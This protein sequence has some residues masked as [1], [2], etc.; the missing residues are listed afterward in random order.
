MNLKLD[1]EQILE[2]MKAFYTLSGIR[3]VLFDADFG[4]IISFPGEDCD[5]CRIMKGNPKT[6]RKCN[7][8]DRRSFEKCREK[9]SF[10]IYECH[11]G[12]VEAVMPLRDSEKIIGYLMF[13]QITNN[14]NKEGIYLKINS[15]GIE[16]AKEVMEAAEKIPVKSD[17]Q[18]RAAAK[19]MEACTSY[20]VYKEL[21][22]PEEGRILEG[23]KKYIDGHLG[24]D[25]RAEEL[26]AVLGVGRT[27]LYGIFKKELGMGIS[28]YILKKRLKT[29]KVLLK[30]TELSIPQ[31]A[32][33]TGFADYNYFSRIYKKTFGKSP[34]YYRK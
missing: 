1:S 18:I 15:P 14:E 6:R 16:L 12:L 28:A 7:Y 22:V 11:A 13:G 24:E 27:K 3:L 33:Q 5:F 19:L 29:A 25:I 8:A 32:S 21:A 17:E 30:T 2:L 9:E 31:I 26:C 4:R 20:I 23:A 34:G 10:I